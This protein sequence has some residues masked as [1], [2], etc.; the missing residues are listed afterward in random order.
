[1]P[2]EGHMIETVVCLS[3]IYSVQKFGVS[4]IRKNKSSKE[5][6]LFSRNVS[7]NVCNNIKVLTVTFDQFLHPS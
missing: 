4:K 1:M 2:D 7:K 6:D 5:L 3:G